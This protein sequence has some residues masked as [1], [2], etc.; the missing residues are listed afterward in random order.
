MSEQHAGTPPV[1]SIE[2]ER[3]ALGP[4]RRDL[5]P[6]YERWIN[7]LVSSR[8]LGRP[9]LPMTHEAEVGWYDSVSKATDTAPFTIYERAS[10]RPIGT[11]TLHEINHRLGS[12]TFGILIGEADGRGQGHGTEATRLM[13][14]YAF[15]VLGLHN[16]MLSVYA[17]NLAGIRAYQKAGF[18]ECGR[19]RQ[20][21]PVAGRRWDIVF[22]DCLATE[23]ESPRLRRLFVPDAPAP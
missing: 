3:V 2:G 4:L 22:M 18:R 20:A 5:L 15:T 21:M 8:N 1:V 19:R 10:W 9:A 11:T 6:L 7:D 23:F 17:F 14:D 16:V 12:A 13:L